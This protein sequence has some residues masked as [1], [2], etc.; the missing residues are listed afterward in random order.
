[1]DPILCEENITKENSFWLNMLYCTVLYC[2]VQTVLKIR[3]VHCTGSAFMS[4]S[5]ALLNPDWWPGI[6]VKILPVCL[7]QKLAWYRYKSQWL[8]LNYY[9]SPV[10][11]FLMILPSVVVISVAKCQ[12][13]NWR[14]GKG[15]CG[16][17]YLYF[18]PEHDTS[19]RSVHTKMTAC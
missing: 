18:D 1:M 9:S 16:Y 7:W 10:N 14:W 6:K 12:F 5:A 13:G 15:N 8:R 4:E 3:S 11:G 19:K 17:R 2:V